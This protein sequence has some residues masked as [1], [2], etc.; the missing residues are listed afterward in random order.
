MAKLETIALVN[1][2]DRIVVNTADAGAWISQGYKSE[3]EQ[4]PA[5]KIRSK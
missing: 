1:G 5:K 2:A 4:K 3:A